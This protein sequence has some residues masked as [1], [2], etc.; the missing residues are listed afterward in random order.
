MSHI[1]LDNFARLRP[2]FLSGGLMVSVAKVVEGYA[3]DGTIFGSVSGVTARELPGFIRERFV[4]P[5]EVY[6]I[7]D[8]SA[9]YYTMMRLAIAHSVTYIVAPNPST[10]MELVHNAEEYFE[11]YIEDIEKGTL[12]SRVPLRTFCFFRATSYDKQMP[13]RGACFPATGRSC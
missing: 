3:E 5:S 13:L 10:I 6:D 4:T 1:W 2:K 7:K 12:S 9:R 8:Y 11:D